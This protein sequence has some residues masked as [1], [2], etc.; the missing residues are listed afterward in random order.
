[1][2]T[3]ADGE[4]SM[5]FL[6]HDDRAFLIH[7]R[8]T[9]NCCCS[10]TGRCSCALKKEPLDPVPE[11]DRDDASMS[12]APKCEKRRPRALTAQSEGGLTVFANGHHKP[13]H[14]HNNMASKCGLPYVV[15]RAHSIHGPSPS[16]PAN[17][18][19]DNLSHDN[20][21]DVLHRD[22]RV[23]DSLFNAQE[24]ERT[25]KSEHGSPLSSPNSNQSNL[26]RVN[27]QLPPLDLAGITDTL[28]FMQSL[29]GYTAF[30]DQEAPIFSAGLRSAS[31]DWSHYDGLDFNS[32]TFATSP[33]SQAPSFAGFDF[34]TIDQAQPALTATSTSGEISEVEDFVPSNNSSRP[35][36]INHQYGSDL[37][38]SDQ[39]EIDGYRLSTASSY[40]GL[41]QTQML[42]S[43]NFD[44]LDIDAFLK[45]VQTSG[46]YVTANHG[47]PTSGFCDDSK[48][49]LSPSSFDE[50]PHFQFP[51]EESDIF[52]M[53]SFPPT[54][55]PIDQ[56]HSEIPEPSPWAQ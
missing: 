52:W 31:I 33:F 44:S 47:L 36:M 6:S 35:A 51:E 26:D 21:I 29:D 12:S 30:P 2:D 41:P 38:N 23:S 10:H 8:P 32:N 49:G 1:M 3:G 43:D 45:G 54:G 28:N 15:P 9:D 50:M 34:G 39:G 4:T 55:G 37:G 18:S 46:A 48:K 22:S 5:P 20:T 11:S 17:R 53:Q 14:K 25:A 19:V 24:E 40:I 16:G 56:S 42:A 7:D 27:G 13:V